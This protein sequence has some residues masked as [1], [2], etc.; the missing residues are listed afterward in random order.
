MSPSGG[1]WS[2]PSDE[3]TPDDLE[4]EPPE[5][6]QER[7]CHPRRE[8]SSYSMEFGPENDADDEEDNRTRDMD[9]DDE[10]NLPSLPCFS[11][12]AS[13]LFA[14]KYKHSAQ[15]SDDGSMTTLSESIISFGRRHGD[16]TLDDSCFDLLNTS[17]E[18]SP[19]FP[20]NSTQEFF[21]RKPSVPE[22]Q[23]NPNVMELKENDFRKRSASA[24]IPR[25]DT[26][27][28]INEPSPKQR[29]PER[30][31]RK[32]SVKTKR[33]ASLSSEITLLSREQPVVFTL[34]PST[35]AKDE[36]ENEPSTETSSSATSLAERK[37]SIRKPSFETMHPLLPKGKLSRPLQS[38]P[39]QSVMEKP[40]PITPPDIMERFIW[41]HPLPGRQVGDLRV[42]ET[43]RVKVLSMRGLRGSSSQKPVYILG[44]LDSKDIFQS[45]AIAKADSE[46]MLEEFTYDVSIPFNHLHLVAVEAGKIGKPARPIGRVSVK[47]KDLMKVA[48]RDQFYPLR[49][50]SKFSDVQGQICVDIRRMSSSFSIRVVDYSDLNVK[51][52]TELYLHVKCGDGAKEAKRLRI[53]TAGELQM[54]CPRE[55]PLSIKMSL[56]HELLKGLNNVF[57]GQ[58]R[59]EVDDRW[60]NGSKWFYLRPK[61][62]DNDKSRKEGAGLGEMK[63]WFSYTADH[64]LPFTTYQPLFNALTT[65]VK[66]E[67]KA[68]AVALLEN[69]PQVD[70]GALARPLVQIFAHSGDIHSLLHLVYRQEVRKCQDLNTLFRSQ[71][72]ASRMLFELMK[73]YGHQY[74]LTTLKPLIDKIYSE[75]KSCEIDPARI[76]NGDSIEKNTETLLSYFTLCFD[77][78]VESSARCPISLRNI[79]ADLRKTVSAETGRVEIE[80]LAESSFLIMRFF[81]AA[82]LNPKSFG[83]KRDQPD[84]RAS[85][86]LLLISKI[87]QRLA[88]ECVATNP[89]TSKEPWLEPILRQ[90]TDDAHKETMIHFLDK[91]ALQLDT[92]A[93]ANESLAVIKEGYLVESRPRTAR[94]W[95]LIPQQ[96]KRFVYLT[97]DSLC[98]QKSRKGVLDHKGSVLLG[99][100]EKITSGERNTFN[101]E[102]GEVQVEFEAA[103]AA[104]MKDWV[105]EIERQR[106]RGDPNGV[107]LG[108]ELSVMGNADVE[109]ALEEVHLILV[110]HANV[111]VQWRN[112]LENTSTSS[113]P[114]V[115]IPQN[116]EPKDEEVRKQ[117]FATLDNLLAATYAIETIHR[118]AVS[119]YMNHIRNGAGTRENPIGDENYLLLKRKFNID[120]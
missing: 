100:I 44:K 11:P 116:L 41:D 52:A 96:K 56:W 33:P 101:I 99:T 92:K 90:V 77:R 36:K 73:T 103:S 120:P 15:M 63:L 80:R 13:P 35:S 28:T 72:L 62:S 49:V 117:L 7:S 17:A 104:E 22:P 98:W 75:R 93:M 21:P 46:D 43:L 107:T 39:A 82:L 67:Y 1:I 110:E 55:G 111:F 42:V 91:I 10:L 12:I 29:P 88:N 34:E 84:S 113:E 31:L 74:L 24:C 66:I 114:A 108:E 9:E 48:G 3:V 57:H 69:L 32:V 85:R 40:A 115:T 6:K 109:R 5:E 81:A 83:I 102:T 79:F 89:L 58:V 4:K 30:S 60:S 51:D 86:T 53:G 20:R 118:D 61:Q 78:I 37:K 8:S 2:E 68:S 54:D 76:Q 95:S 16:L 97:E 70:L 105:T 18:N 94:R 87:L 50:V 14:P 27:S 45:A 112:S 19:V 47:R 23:L 59:V 64:V 65:S 25:S 26:A 71:S 38:I 119:K 106:L